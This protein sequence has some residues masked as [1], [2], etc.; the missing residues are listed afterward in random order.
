MTVN[1]VNPIFLISSGKIVG[2]VCHWEEGPTPG[3]DCGYVAKFFPK[4]MGLL[5]SPIDYPPKNIPPDPRETFPVLIKGRVGHK[6]RR[7]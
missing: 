4:I 3:S 5:S 1:A 6:K 2:K 7:L